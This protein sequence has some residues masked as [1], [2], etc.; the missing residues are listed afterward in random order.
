MKH[1]K[2]DHNNSISNQADASNSATEKTRPYI[3]VVEDSPTTLAVINRNLSYQFDI[4]NAID[5]KEAW[6]ILHDDEN[7]ELVITDINMPE[8][9][10][11]EL[12][13][14]LRADEDKRLAA[15]PVFVMT[16]NDGD[17]DKHL[18]FINGANDFI[19]KPIDPMELQARVNVH[20]KLAMTIRELE[21]NKIKLEEQARTDPLTKLMNRRVIFE[22]GSKA[23]S[24]ALR[25]N[26]NFSVILIDL[27]HFKKVNDSYGH[28]GGDKIL[29][30]V[31]NLL[32]SLTRDVDTVARIGGEEFAILLPDTSR[33]GAAVLAERMCATVDH[34]KIDVD[35]NIVHVTISAGVASYPTEKVENFED[36]MK[37]ADKRLYMAKELGRNRICISDD[38]KLNSID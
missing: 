9:T 17:D 19:T 28:H 37:I 34:E 26:S 11:H 6:E 4:I 33:L 38:D 18:A 7:I 36:I 24:Q 8:M 1:E 21:S 31:S 27:D 29:I 10:G 5:G 14:K 22:H 30:V 25:Y 20:H 16:A 35:D 13:L 15:M 32:K 12:L 23:Y 2:S 3:L